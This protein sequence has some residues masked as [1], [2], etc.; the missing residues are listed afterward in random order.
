M[1]GHPAAP[2]A[3]L[4]VE[5]GRAPRRTA[6]ETGRRRAR[7]RYLPLLWRV[8]AINAVVLVVACV[9]TIR[10]LS[11]GSLT[12]VAPEEAVILAVAL[13]AMVAA[14]I[15][16]LHRAFV[17]LQRLTRFV[18]ELD[19]TRTGQR[20]PVD[21]HDSEAGELAGAVNDMLGRLEAERRE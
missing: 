10:V 17:P 2:L 21:R 3:E 5:V 15:F 9:V 13:S 20:V 11:P 1:T 6:A 18:R 8:V 16:L 19:P 7:P 4:D 12:S 14:T